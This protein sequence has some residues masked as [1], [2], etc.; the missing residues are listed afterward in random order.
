M[1]CRTRCQRIGIT[2]DR[3]EVIRSDFILQGKGGHQQHVERSNADGATA[4]TYRHQPH[5]HRLLYLKLRQLYRGCPLKMHSAPLWA[6]GGPTYH[7]KTQLTIKKP[8]ILSS[9]SSWQ[10]ATNG[11]N[12]ILNRSRGQ[13]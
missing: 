2:N 7:G 10:L 9:C 8:R 11:F 6:A 5:R 12:V 3:S 1:N 13:H 4:E